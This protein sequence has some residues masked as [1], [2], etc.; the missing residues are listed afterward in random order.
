MISEKL[1][2]KFNLQSTGFMIIGLSGA[3]LYG[4]IIRL[5]SGFLIAKLLLPDLLGLF[6]SFA[7][8]LGYLVVV[9]LGIMN[10]LNRELPYLI[11]KGNK[12][13]AYEYAATAQWWE[14]F[15]SLI[16]FL[17]LFSVSIYFFVLEQ[18]LYAAGIFTFSLASVHLFYGVNYLQIL[19]RTNG[20]FNKLS[21]NSIVVSSVG[22]IG[23]TFIWLWG[24]WGL[25]LRYILNIVIELFLLWKWKPISVK[26]AFDK[27]VFKKMLT[28]GFPIFLVGIVFS[29]WGTLNDTL[30]F[31][32]GGAKNL[33]LYSLATM[34]IGSL[35]IVANSVNQVIYPK[36][37][38]LNGQGSSLAEMYKIP[39]KALKLYLLFI[40]PTI[41]V[42]YFFIPIMVNFLLPE[43]ANGI[44]VAQ[45]S[46]PL[47]VLNG[48][49]V[50]NLLFNVINKQKDYLI[51]ILTGISFFLISLFL[52]YSFF[53]FNLILFP[54]S[55]FIGRL[56]Q[57]V[58]A[59][60]YLKSYVS[61]SLNP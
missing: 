35:T 37:S 2:E 32:L 58:I 50:Y 47:L 13:I 53:G 26:P 31:Q 44:L 21:M 12:E 24:Y 7:L 33:G 18:Y 55:L 54:V 8:I 49:G 5:L 36:L 42:L 39:A 27:T 16:S 57:L 48:F 59:Y 25:C 40:I 4:N 22:L 3:Q 61:T 15:L 11:G 46:L 19:Y 43:Y 41:V 14:I 56:F 45:W 6:N 23:V 17:V 29:L 9:Q 30:L 34:I 10:A 60:F 20:D 38:F 52:L 1:K 28:I 51:S